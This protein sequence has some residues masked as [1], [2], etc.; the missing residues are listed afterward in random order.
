MGALHVKRWLAVTVDS[1][2]E[3]DIHN[4]ER[5]EGLPPAD[6]AEQWGGRDAELL[7]DALAYRL[8][9]AQTDWSLATR[10]REPRTT[11]KEKLALS[12][13]RAGALVEYDAQLRTTAGFVF[14]HRLM[15]PPELRIERLSLE[16]D[17]TE[18][19]A[20]WGRDEVGVVTLFLNRRV[21]GAQRL[22]LQGW[23]PAP[24]GARMPLPRLT[25]EPGDPA[26]TSERAEILDRSI[27][28]HR[29]PSAL[30]T[31]TGIHGLVEATEP[32]ADAPNRRLGRLV[33]SYSA[34]GDYGATLTIAPNEP[35]VHSATQLVSLKLRDQSWIAACGLRFMVDGGSLDAL[36]F[37]LPANW[38][39]P[40]EV[41]PAAT[42]EICDQPGKNGKQLVVRPR[43]PWH[44]LASLRIEAPLKSSP[45]NPI[46]APDVVPQLPEVERFVALPVQVGLESVSWETARLVAAPLPEPLAD[47]ST[48]PEKLNVY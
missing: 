44:G 37:E 23:L 15:V 13:D 34:T 28:I 31:L 42:V 7:R 47:A 32:L 1:G 26:V 10:T 40:F 9:E 33:A 43:S 25:I 14:E 3:Y 8:P 38:H 19:L 30:V 12:F 17:G 20:H 16:E 2:L 6:F 41:T 24:T 27:R 45:G 48:S 22:L 39:G 11:V 21:T 4:D 18:R 5:L 46:A 35:R 36:R 29:Q